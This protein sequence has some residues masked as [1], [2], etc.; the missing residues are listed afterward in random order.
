[1]SR[2]PIQVKVDEQGQGTLVVDGIDI[3]NST[4]GVQVCTDVISGT[5]VEVRL[6]VGRVDVDAQAHVHLDEDTCAVLARLGWSP[7]QGAGDTTPPCCTPTSP[8]PAG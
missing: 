7:P 8:H 2:V 5:V 4:V 1:M 3:S 6:I